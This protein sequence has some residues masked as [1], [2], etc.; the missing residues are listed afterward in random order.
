[1]RTSIERPL[2]NGHRKKPL[3]EKHEEVDG[4]DA[5]NPTKKKQ[6]AK[7][8]SD[9]EER[10][11][12]IM[13]SLET[14]TILIPSE[15]IAHSEVPLPSPILQ[16]EEKIQML[17][18]LQQRARLSST[19][20]P[21][22][23]FYT[24][25]NSSDCVNSISISNDGSLVSAGLSD[26][27]VRTWDL[28]AHLKPGEYEK[29]KYQSQ[30]APMYKRSDYPVDSKPSD[31]TVPGYSK[32]IGHCGSVYS[33]HLSHDHQFLLSSSE[34]ATVRLWHMDSKMN[35]VAYK[36]HNSP[37]WSVRFSPLGFYFATASN[38]CTAR[39]WST[40]KISP[41]RIFVGHTASVD[42][43]EFHPNCNYIATGSADKCVRLWDVNK[44]ES[45]RLFRG[46]AAGIR[47]LA[48]SPDGRCVAAAGEDHNVYVWDL[49]SGKQM[50]KF[51][52]HQ[53]TVTSLDFS[54]E[55]SLLASGSLDQ[56]VRLWSMEATSSNESKQ[57]I[58]TVRTKTSSVTHVN[59]TGRNLL[60]CAGVFLAGTLSS[61]RYLVD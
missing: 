47:A 3:D 52:G 34:D 40:D 5:T 22:I 36:G 21:S 46:P 27:S 57:A 2:N 53:G 55:G 25:V 33:T 39:L 9:E 29:F 18:D 23:C 20:L 10:E 43:V 38:D 14:A 41:L 12:E 15:T 6:R 60:M 24:F 30:Q 49:A 56:T 28:K 44:G 51:V 17:A 19:A 58:R 48:L 32:L 42:C 59:F 45:V 1:L 54:R 13:E 8:G 31:P 37:V 50:E 4:T 11:D 7:E 26:S 61:A 16:E 35:F